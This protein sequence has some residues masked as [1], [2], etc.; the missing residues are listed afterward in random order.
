MNILDIACH[1]DGG[2]LYSNGVQY[3]SVC[4]EPMPPVEVM[5]LWT[6]VYIVVTMPFIVLLVVRRIASL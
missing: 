4:A 6:G 1:R 2:T 3:I 5:P